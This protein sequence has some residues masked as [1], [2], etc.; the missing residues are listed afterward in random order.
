MNDDRRRA[1]AYLSQAYRL[2]QRIDGKLLQLSQLKDMAVHVTTTIN[3]MKVQ[4]SPN[5]QK[6]ESTVLKIIEQ[7]K[8]LNDE[9]DRLVDLKSEIKKV[10]EAV[11]S[12]EQRFLLEERYLCYRSWE[13]IAAEMDYG[14]DNVF[15]LHQKALQNITIP[16]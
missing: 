2:N 14:I 4:S 8:N 10:I 16:E 11:E 15:K 3:D 7:E 6:M 12:P 9:I 5:L 13:K 1:R